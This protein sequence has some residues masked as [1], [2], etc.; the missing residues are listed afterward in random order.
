MIKCRIVEKMKERRV[1]LISD[2]AGA[3]ES[4]DDRVQEERI[5]GLYNE[6]E[7]D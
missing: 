5:G 6:Q 7:T 2:I 4:L 3:E 1:A